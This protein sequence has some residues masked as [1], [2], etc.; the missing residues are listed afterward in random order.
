MRHSP[1]GKI[2]FVYRG[3]VREVTFLIESEKMR[4]SDLKIKA[5]G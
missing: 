3:T 5:K 1:R 2:F 4:F